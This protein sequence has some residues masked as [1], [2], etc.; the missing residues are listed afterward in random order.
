MKHCIIGLV[1]VVF[2]GVMV[3]P[4]AALV[5]LGTLPN[6]GTLVNYRGDL[7]HGE[8]DYFTFSLSGDVI[9]NNGSYLN[10]QT[11]G[12]R[13]RRF[14][15]M[16]T[17][18]GLYNSAGMLVACDDNDNG[19]DRYGPRYTDKYSLL[20]FGN[21]D[22]WGDT[23]DSNPGQ[24]GTVSAGNYTLI[25]GAYN[26]IFTPRIE[27]VYTLCE[28]GDYI[29]Q[30]AFECPEPVGDVV[31]EP[32]TLI[33]WSLLGLAFSGAGGMSVWRQRRQDAFGVA[34]GQPR[35]PWSE[36]N[37]QAILRVIDRGRTHR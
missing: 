14:D 33:I 11:Y 21:S 20:T 36:E 9:N 37:R 26:T 4:A 1:G 2:L 6:D 17:E 13:E 22:P 3:C 27:D 15:L 32:A 16:N 30:C 8:L 29:L 10:I 19:N 18:I 35:T 12:L 24:D 25:V 23:V 28:P 31:P 34:G 5:S 7:L